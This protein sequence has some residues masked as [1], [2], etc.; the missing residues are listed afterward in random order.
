MT[1]FIVDEEEVDQHGL[2]VRGNKPKKIIPM[3]ALGISSSALWNGD[4]DEIFHLSCAS[5]PKH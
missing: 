3:Q 5:A 2:L 1:N 4:I